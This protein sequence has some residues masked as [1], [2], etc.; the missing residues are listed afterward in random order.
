MDV[1]V[2]A[3]VILGAIFA[4]VARKTK[5]ELPVLLGAMIVGVIPVPVGFMVN[6]ALGSLMGGILLVLGVACIIGGL[7]GLLRTVFGAS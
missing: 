1:L 2:W 4:Y 7:A 3:A 5:Q 6:L